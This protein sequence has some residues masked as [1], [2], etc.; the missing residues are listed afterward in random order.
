[1]NR[2]IPLAAALC[3][4]LSF[5]VFPVYASETFP[6]IVITPTRTQER[7]NT[8]SSTLFVIDRQRIEQSG[9]TNTAQLLRGVP[10]LQ[11]DDLFGNG[12]DVLVSIRGFSSTANANTLVLVDGRRL[13]HGD[14]AGPDL[15]HIFP[16]DIERIEVLSGSAGVLYG[17]QA[18]GG[19]VNI[20]T[21]KAAG[22]GGEITLSGGSFGYRGTAFSDSRTIVN[23]EASMTYRLAA[24]RFLA[25]HYRDHNRQSN[26]N[27][28]GYFEYV[29]DHHGLSF[30]FQ[31]IEDRLELP[32]A[33]LEN[34]FEADPTSI[35]TGFANDFGNE[36]T[37]VTVVGY[38][39]Q[40]GRH[41]F[42]MDVSERVSD[43]EVLQSFRDSPSPAAGFIARR[44]V[45]WTPAL[46]GVLDF[47]GVETPYVT[48]VDIEDA[49]FELSL[50]NQFGTSTSS[51]EQR[52]ESLYLQLRPQLDERTALTVGVRHSR[53]DK[54]MTNG[55]SFPNGLRFEDDQSVAELGLA[56]QISGSLKWTL[57]TDQN[58]RFAKV[59]ELAQAEPGKTLKTQTGISY[60]TGLIWSDA[61]HEWTLS[62][63]RLE[64]ENE[65]VFDPTVDTDPTNSFVEGANV[66]LRET[67]REGINVLGSITLDEALRLG[68][69]LSWIDATFASGVFAGK[70]ISGVADNS[71]GLRLDYHVNPGLDVW[72]QARR[73]G[74]YYAQGDNANASGEIDGPTIVNLGLNYQH[75]QWTLNARI[76]NLTDRNYAEFITNNG[77]GAAFQPSPDRNFMLTAGYRFE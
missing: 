36:D 70:R 45:G 62:A 58:F 75:M 69:E 37:S 12:T 51:N 56:R 21:R 23:D 7:E 28:Q 31:R 65:I 38:H 48:G 4:T 67:L 33:L 43:A 17:D 63:F 49:E 25:D 5:P 27:V 16:K 20:I 22:R 59:D 44:H 29:R 11:V 76:N 46:S 19:V 55:F 13:N 9:A 8:T 53:I 68:L 26:S 47:G 30:E 14:T 6:L 52:T 41:R 1:M 15:H 74:G 24:Q 3:G 77:F 32:G 66:N 72:L 10:G 2:N 73:K 40:F 54:D 35:N 64:L 71:V 18:V 60:E 61:G 57:R 34:E 39:R 50:P 42:S